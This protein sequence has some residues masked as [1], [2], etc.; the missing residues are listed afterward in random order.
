MFFHLI[1]AFSLVGGFTITFLIMWLPGGVGSPKV[2]V[3]HGE[4][5]G[6]ALAPAGGGA[7]APAAAAPA[8]AAAPTAAGEVGKTSE[9]AADAVAVVASAADA[10]A[11]HSGGSGPVAVAVGHAGGNDWVH[12]TV[13]NTRW[14]RAF[15]AVV[16]TA[17]AI[18]FITGPIMAAEMW[19][20]A[21]E[22]ATWVAWFSAKMVA[23]TLFSFFSSA[24]I[25][26]SPCL[27]AFRRHARI[28][29]PINLVLGFFIVLAGTAVRALE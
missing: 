26:R 3:G 28:V 18:Q 23:V 27:A 10:G 14:G 24:L 20:E 5:E 6:I 21:S 29:A 22:S 13:K 4:G 19:H 25:G 9:A 17:L 7:A 16:H 1:G 2:E 12:P 15:F 11:A 8:A